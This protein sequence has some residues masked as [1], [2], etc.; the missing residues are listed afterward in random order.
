MC[1]AA[2]G[3][4]SKRDVKPVVAGTLPCGT[5]HVPA[6]LDTPL[7]PGLSP[8]S[9]HGAAHPADGSEEGTTVALR[10]SAH[11]IGSLRAVKV[12]ATLEYAP[13]D[14][15]REAIARGSNVV[16]VTPL[17]AVVRNGCTSTTFPEITMNHQGVSEISFEETYCVPPEQ[18]AR[19]LFS[20]LPHGSDY[21]ERLIECLATGYLVA[22]IESICIR[23]MQLHVDAATEVVVGRT[24]QLEHKGPIPP[25][26]SLKLRGW[27]ERLG[28]RSATFCVQVSDEHEVV[29][30]SSVT[31]V[32]AQRASMESRIAAKVEALVASPAGDWLGGARG[33]CAARV[34][35]SSSQEAETS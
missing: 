25:G 34:L 18:T 21:A 22:V 11:G 19:A 3:R 20:R 12:P 35:T 9:L 13:M 10:L 33:R 5:N 2:Q 8:E 30:E 28:E 1:L 15:S 32:A 31:L 7:P 17:C 29:C 6:R 16:P 23:E 14:W 27:V 4:C 24:I 26:S